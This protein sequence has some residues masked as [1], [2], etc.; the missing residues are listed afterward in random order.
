MND[1]R[2]LTWEHLAYITAEQNGTAQADV[3]VGEDFHRVLHARCLFDVVTG[4][5]GHGSAPS[6]VDELLTFCQS[7]TQISYLRQGQYLS[8]PFV[9]LYTGHCRIDSSGENVSQN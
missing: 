5:R 9:A 1:I 3:V 4:F 2:V 7:K 6:G 8:S